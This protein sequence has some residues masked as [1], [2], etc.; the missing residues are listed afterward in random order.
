MYVVCAR[1]QVNALASGGAAPARGE[2]SSR[3]LQGQDGLG[4]VWESEFWAENK[5]GSLNLRIQSEL[6]THSEVVSSPK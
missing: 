5:G 2:Y 1:S 3:V 6:Y 4:R